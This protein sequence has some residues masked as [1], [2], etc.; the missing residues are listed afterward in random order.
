MEALSGALT[1][2]ELAAKHDVHPNMISQ[3][4]RTKELLACVAERGLPLGRATREL[5]ELLRTFGHKD[6]E[7][8]V[9]EAISRQTP[10]P[11]AV[12]HILE[13]NRR[14][15]GRSPARP[16]PL[17]DDPRVKNLFVKPHDLKSYEMEED[18]DE[19]DKEK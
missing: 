15:R 6:L 9:V 1:L 7:A 11:A 12:R 10:H 19:N 17:P 3:W 16:L 8:A 4:K 5:M 2:A 18:I 14:S 13:R